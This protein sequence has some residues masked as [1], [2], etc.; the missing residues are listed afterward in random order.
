MIGLE[1]TQGVADIISRSRRFRDFGRSKIDVPLVFRAKVDD[2]WTADP[3]RLFLDLRQ[4]PR[5]GRE[6]ADRHA[7]RSSAFEQAP[8]Q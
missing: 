3:L 8:S 7:R 5:R 1:I 6:Q 4:D 2:V